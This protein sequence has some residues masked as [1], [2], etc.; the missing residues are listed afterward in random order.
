MRL[1]RSPASWLLAALCQ[2]GDAGSAEAASVMGPL[3]GEFGFLSQFYNITPQEARER[4]QTLHIAF[5]VMEFELRDAFESFSKPPSAHEQEWGAPVGDGRIRREIIQAYA[6]EAAALGGR[7]WLVVNAAATDPGDGELQGNATVAGQFSVGGA[8]L[9]DVVVPDARWAEAFAPDWAD[10]ARTLG[11]SG[12]LWSTVGDYNG[13]TRKGA[14]FKG[15]LE[16]SQPLLGARGLGQAANFVDAFGWD[17][18][19]AASQALAFVYWSAWDIPRREDQF[20]DEAPNGSVLSILPG[21]S[22]EHEGES[23]NRYVKGIRPLDV[24]VLRWQKARCRGHAYFA[25]GDGSRFA[26]GD[27]LPDARNMSLEEIKKVRR[28]VFGSHACENGATPDSLLPFSGGSLDDLPGPSSAARPSSGGSVKRRRGSFI[29]EMSGN[30][31]DFDVYKPVFEATLRSMYGLQDVSL[32]TKDHKRLLSDATQ[33]SKFVSEFDVSFACKGRC[34]IGSV[35]SDELKASLQRAVLSTG[36]LDTVAGAR[37]G[38][39]AAAGAHAERPPEAGGAPAARAL[40]SVPA[41][42]AW[43]AIPVSGGLLGAVLG[44]GAAARRRMETMDS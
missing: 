43:C 21:E 22:K 24:A 38:L 19:L 25:V 26:G 12:I 23:W 40:Q 32:E 5:G 16:A 2:R 20:F 42:A 13:S 17:R 14:D 28:E 37:F 4:V 29:V 44:A 1:A 27:H 10:W 33:L 6:S 35:S 15:F 3:R 11:C 41:W 36:S 30:Q 7:S 39:G 34:S 31:D 18:G 9:M 8:P